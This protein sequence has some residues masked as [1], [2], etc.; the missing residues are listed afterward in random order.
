[1][2]EIK[3]DAEQKQKLTIAGLVACAGAAGG[4][5]SWLYSYITTFALPL[6]ITPWFGIPV[7][8]IFGA[9]ASIFGVYLVA[10]TDRT[11]LTRCLSFALLC[12]MF[13]HPVIKASE[14][15][16]A[17][18]VNETIM[19]ARELADASNYLKKKAA[20]PD[21]DQIDQE[22]LVEEITDQTE[23]AMKLFD[24]INTTDNTSVTEEAR[25]SQK[26]FIKTLE[27]IKKVEPVK[28]SESLIKIAEEG[29]IKDKEK[30]T[31][32]IAIDVIAQVDEKNVNKDLVNTIFTGLGEVAEAARAFGDKKALSFSSTTRGLSPA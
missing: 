18:S 16:L 17:K 4:L 3:L 15:M 20:L 7:S 8:I 6:G 25:I 31:T 13:W 9:A 32:S 21:A 2:P 10:N 29:A 22:E 26:R 11:Q 23:A 5:L 14:N 27:G 24:K 1:M 12:G 28:A 30:T 19:K